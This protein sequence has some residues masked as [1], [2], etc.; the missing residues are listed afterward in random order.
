MDMREREREREREE[1]RGRELFVL[2]VSPLTALE[3]TWPTIRRLPALKRPGLEAYLIISTQWRDK[4]GTKLVLH[5]PL[6]LLDNAL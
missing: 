5:F 6:R 4:E 1:K 3:L 2:C